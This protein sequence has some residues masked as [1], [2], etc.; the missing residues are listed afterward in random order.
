MRRSIGLFTVALAAMLLATT[1]AQANDTKGSVLNKKAKTTNEPTEA[2]TG[3]PAKEQKV[4]RTHEDLGVTQ[5]EK[6]RAAAA[7]QTATVEEQRI[8]GQLRGLQLLMQKEEQ[9]LA[10]R[11][12]YAAKLRAQGLS[13]NDQKLLDQ[14]ERLERQALDY[15]QKRVQQFETTQITP[16]KS[17]TQGTKAQQQP[18]R[19]RSSS[20]SR[21]SSNNYR[22][23]R[24]SSRYRSR[25]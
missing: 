5:E 22:S 19:A 9:A 16:S 14:A 18:T 13:K 7:Q 4:V 12:A 15:Y 25:R 23:T 20:S 1:V 24:S 21:S 2:K 6:Q 8:A 3:D 10:Q 17:T 11:L